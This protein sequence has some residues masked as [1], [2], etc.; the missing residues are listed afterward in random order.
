MDAVWLVV[1]LGNPG[2]RYAGTRHNLG[3]MVLDEL[4]RRRSESFRS[5]PARAAVAQTRLAPGA[6]RMVLAKP[7]TF[8]NVSGGPVAA[9]VAYFRVPPERIIVVHDELD[10]PFDTLRL[11]QGGSAGGHNGVKDVAAALG[12]EQ[13]VRV[14]VGVGRPPGRTDPTDWLLREFTPAERQA[15]PNL[16]VDAA[17]ATEDLIRIG[18]SGAQQRWHSPR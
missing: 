13:F 9:L 1:G 7:A 14:R 2:A 15:L 3:Q 16:V 8:M 12:T 10:I 6:D 4:A 5:H 17:D 18:L 11:K